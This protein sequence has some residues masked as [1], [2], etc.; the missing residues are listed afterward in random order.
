MERQRN[1]RTRRYQIERPRRP[2][3]KRGEAKKKKLVHYLST[4]KIL[5]SM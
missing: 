2:M 4:G 3:G 1:H 5:D